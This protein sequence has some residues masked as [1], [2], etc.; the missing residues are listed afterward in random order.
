[1]TADITHLVFSVLL[2]CWAAHLCANIGSLVAAS[3]STAS[4]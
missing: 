3:A 4:L 1:M 2:A